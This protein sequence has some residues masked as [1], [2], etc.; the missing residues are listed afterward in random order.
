MKARATGSKSSTTAW[1]ETDRVP[2][3]G[4]TGRQHRSQACSPSP[5]RIPWQP[6][7]RRRPAP[8]SA[9]PPRN[10]AMSTGGLDLGSPLKTPLG[11][12][13]PTFGQPGTPYGIGNGFDGIADVMRIITAHPEQH[14][15]RAVQRPHGL[16]ADR[17][18]PRGLQHLLGPHRHP[19]HQRSRTQPEPVE[20]RP[21][22][23]LLDRDLEPH[24]LAHHL[25]E[26]RFGQSGWKFDETRFQ[27]AGALGTA[28][29]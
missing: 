16:P 15:Q 2:P 14:H 20:Q 12:T 8:R 25:N 21:S 3:E 24:L 11:T 17:E 1:F 29:E 28:D 18:R 13:D 9:S 19:H 5:V 26:A 10:A 22:L 7:F 27:H 23:A 4:R 6:A